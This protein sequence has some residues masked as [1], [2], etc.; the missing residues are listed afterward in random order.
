MLIGKYTNVLDAKGR[1]FVPAAFRSDLGERFVLTRGFE[2][3][4]LYIYPL[5]EWQ[6]F[7]EK[8]QQK[9]KA[10]K[11]DNR[12]I[13]RYFCANAVNCEMDSQGRVVIPQE[14][15]EKAQLDKEVVFIGTMTRVE[16]WSGENVKETEV[17]D[18]GGLIESLDLDF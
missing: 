4:S 7:V 18:I 8:L 11:S 6:S 12:D 15:R 2:N 9:L 14:L 1:V 17:E 10:S 3:K 16:L 5:D 13:F